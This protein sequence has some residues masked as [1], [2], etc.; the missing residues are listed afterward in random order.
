[1]LSWSVFSLLLWIPTESRTKLKKLFNLNHRW[2]WGTTPHIYGLHT[3]YFFIKNYNN[4][5]SFWVENNFRFISDCRNSF[6][7]KLKKLI[8][9]Q[10]NLYIPTNILCLLV[11]SLQINIWS[12]I[13]S[14]YVSTFLLVQF[15]EFLFM[16]TY[17]VLTDW[18]NV[19][20]TINQIIL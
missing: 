2:T 3:S 1:M 8:N 4:V 10:K 5:G 11:E 16:K 17:R 9:K 14:W 7:G 20:Y 19:R 12:I 18:A 15:A 13:L 6:N